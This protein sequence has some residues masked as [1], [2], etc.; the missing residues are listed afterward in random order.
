MLFKPHLRPVIIAKGSSQMS[1]LVLAIDDDKF[2][3]SLIQQTLH[4]YCEVTVAENG[5]QGIRAAIKKSP[6]IILLDVEMP[7]MTGYEVCQM[8]KRDSST[9]DIPVMFISGRGALSDRIRGYNS[10]ADD[11]IVKPFEKDELLARI[12]VLYQYR[13]RSISLKEH[14]AHAESTAEMALTDFSDMG[15]VMRYVGQT[16]NAHSLARLSDYFFEFFAPLELNVVL[17]FWYKEGNE[18]FSNHD[19]V[20][21]LEEELLNKC[22]DGER[23]I[24]FGARTIINYPKV[25][26]LIK[27]MPL[28]DAATYGRFKDLFPHLLEATNA[29]VMSMEINEMIFDQANEI[30]DTFNLV[31]TTLRNQIED[32]YAHG[33]TSVEMVESLYNNFINVIPT[34][35]LEDEQEEF[36]LNSVEHTVKEL[37]QHLQL[38]QQMRSSFNDVIVYMEHIMMQRT[39][40]LERFS[41]LHQEETINEVTSQIDIELF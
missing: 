28:A 32:I 27:N 35:D 11:Y 25:S 34:L 21:P 39:Q 12:E 16:Y 36:V 37:Q 38:T 41:Q 30:T 15:R 23:F 4:D 31:D 6:D 33:Q 5:E 7:G 3:R 26:L 2:I 29:K 18:F 1:K 24:D 13:Q 19:A 40:M 22:R 20:C 9:N 17:V 10:G 8:L 14:I